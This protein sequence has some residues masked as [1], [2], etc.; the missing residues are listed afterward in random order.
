MSLS[1]SSLRKPTLGELG[2]DLLRLSLGQ[3]LL[4]ISLPLLFALLFVPLA[5]SG[6]WGGAI[7]AAAAYSFYSY[8]STSH[9]LVHGSLR[10]APA[11]NHLFLSF[12]EIVGL[13]SGH[14]YR[15]AH[16]HHHAVFPDRDDIEG[17]AAHGSLISA[18][19]AG[20]CHQPRIFWWAIRHARRERGWIVGETLA[21]VALV[22]A[23][24]AACPITS[25][26][27]IWVA[28]VVMGSWTF[29]FVTAYFPHDPHAARA[30]TQTLRF[31]G[32]ASDVLF[33]GHLYH[34]EHHLY[35]AVPHQRWR[36]LA[37]RLDPYL[38]AASV[39]AIYF[40]VWGSAGAGN[41]LRPFHCGRAIK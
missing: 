25:E 24:A 20:P 16:L 14:A 38:D 41:R 29:P 2:G 37:E 7:L 26:P 31:R 12:I 13:R 21:C 28:L 4:S 22:L 35:P 9:D 34:L 36:E 19:L 10:L 1:S 30:L 8:G 27:I 40:G 11:A 32:I 33:R 3:R 23:S 39:P 15:A 18:F 5:I 6:I 17:A